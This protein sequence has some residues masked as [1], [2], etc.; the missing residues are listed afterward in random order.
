MDKLVV[1]G[2]PISHSRSPEI[3]HAFAK[4]LGIELNYEKLHVKPEDLETSIENFFTQGGKGMNVTVPHKG[5]AFAMADIV[6]PAAKAAKA[7]NTLY[8]QEGE[9]VADNTDGRGLLQD[10]THNLGWTL[11]AKRIL[12][13]GAGGAVR[14]VLKSLLCANPEQIVVAN[15]TVEKARELAVT[16]GVDFSALN[17]LDEAFDIV[18]NATSAG[19]GGERPAVPDCII[20]EQTYAYDMVYGAA[21]TSF[22]EW[23]LGNGAVQASDGL[24]MLVEQAAASFEMWYGQR[25][26][27]RDVLQ[28]M[29]ESL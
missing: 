20:G 29:R 23:A 8:L 19:L 14:G 16:F 3:H 13:I 2:D 18:I 10:L 28:A 4:A 6:T 17:E 12:I 15:R 22:M 27:T 7:A 9:L 26:V 11:K 21:P 24:G 5:G 25:P 1:I